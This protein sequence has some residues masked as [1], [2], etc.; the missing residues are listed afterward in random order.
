MNILIVSKDIFF[1]SGVITVV[2]RAWRPDYKT[3]PVFLISDDANQSLLLPDII[4]NDV[5]ET[6]A[7]KHRALK[8]TRFSGRFVTLVLAAQHR[9]CENIRCAKHSIRL[10]KKEAAT[11]LSMLFGHPDSV[12]FS[13]SASLPPTAGNYPP[14]IELSKQQAMV[15][16]YI[17]QGLSL[18]DIS[19]L[20]RLSVKTI[21]TH[22][23]AIMRKLGMKNNSEFYQYTL[24]DPLRR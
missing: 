12:I 13:S 20:T 22:K 23:R 2:T 3:H 9:E 10:N 15:V 24:A 17:R 18:T 21:S 19:H 6:E 14:Q 7:G 16:R 4:I 1:I 8:K 11:Q 5:I